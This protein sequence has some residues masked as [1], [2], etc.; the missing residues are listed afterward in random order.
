MAAGRH[1]RG[2]LIVVA[3]AIAAGLWTHYYFVLAYLPILPAKRR[4]SFGSGAWIAVLG[5]RS[6]PRG[7][8]LGRSC[9]WPA[10]R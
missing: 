8:W 3:L 10:R 1:V 5:W 2:H 4:D 6:S 7:C 9:S